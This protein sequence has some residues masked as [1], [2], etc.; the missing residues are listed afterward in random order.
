M[1]KRLDNANTPV[2]GCRIEVFNNTRDKVR[3]EV[4]KE[5]SDGDQA[6]A[7]TLGV[8]GNQQRLLGWSHVE[9]ST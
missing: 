4:R 9:F 5:G 7:R 1:V 8:V 6:N 2:Q 3:F